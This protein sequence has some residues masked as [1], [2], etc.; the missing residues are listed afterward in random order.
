MSQAN[1]PLQS[2]AG[3]TAGKAA[4]DAFVRVAKYTLARTTVLFGPVVVAVYLTIFIANLGGYVDE[5][6]RNNIAWAIAGMRLGG[7]LKDVPTEE[8]NQIIEQTMW[9]MEEEAGLHE[10]FMARSVRWLWLG[11]TLDWGETSVDSS[12]WS[13]VTKI[14]AGRHTGGELAHRQAF[15]SGDSLFAFSRS[16]LVPRRGIGITA[17]IGP[18]LLFSILLATGPF[19][20]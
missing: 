16:A 20:A 3:P 15:R 14:E 2:N 7:W 1:L 5:I 6:V 10:P 19:W 17:M 13:S 8:R 12:P 18:I 11:L 9:H 4:S